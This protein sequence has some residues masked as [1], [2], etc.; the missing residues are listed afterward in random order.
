VKLMD[1]KQTCKVNKQIMKLIESKYT[2]LFPAAY[3]T[4][5]ARYY[6]MLERD[7]AQAEEALKHGGIATN[8]DKE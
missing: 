1:L 5:E 7:T 6:R 3:N 2:E 8:E 4:P